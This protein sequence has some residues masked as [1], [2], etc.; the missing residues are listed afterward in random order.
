M[1]KR[2]RTPSPSPSTPPTATNVLNSENRSDLHSHQSQKIIHVDVDVDPAPVMMTCTYPPHAPLFFASYSQYEAH[3]ELNH[4]NRCSEC[5]KNFPTEMYLTLHIA[6][7]HDPITA[8][9]RDRGEKT[10]ACFVEGCEKACETWQKRRLHLIDKHKFPRDFEFFIVNDG[11]DGKSSML[12]SDHGLRQSRPRKPAHGTAAPEGISSKQP[13]GG[14]SKG[15][16][17]HIIPKP[18]HAIAEKDDVDMI[19]N[20]LQSLKFV[21]SKVR[22]GRKTGPSG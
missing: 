1:V 2:S 5:H 14:T 22:F 15:V 11:V 8:I 10:Y 16:D 7:S 6:E 17:L 9:R 21:P 13:Q 4:V 20:S 18:A 3:Y 19:S 12:R